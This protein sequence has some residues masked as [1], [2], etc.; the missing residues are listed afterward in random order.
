MD[1]APTTLSSRASRWQARR[2]SGAAWSGHVQL[3]SLDSPFQ[4][5]SGMLASK[6]GEWQ[7]EWSR[8]EPATVAELCRIPGAQAALADYIGILQEW[9]SRSDQDG[10]A[11]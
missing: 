2:R 5:P 11:P 4:R 10:A 9:S 8:G 3:R 6:A 1:L 7:L